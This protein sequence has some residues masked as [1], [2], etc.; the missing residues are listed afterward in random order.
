MTKDDIQNYRVLALKYRPTTFDQLIGQEAM[1]RTLENSFGTNRLA[2]AFILT[3]VRGV[4]KT[5]TARIIARALNCTGPKQSQP[6]RFD[7]CGKCEN[8]VAIFE[9]RHVDVLEIDAASHTGVDRMRAIIDSVH[10]SPVSAKSKVYI[11]DEIHMLST[12]AF[13]ALLK[14]LE[15]PPPNVT[16][17]F[18]TTEIRKVP[19]TVLS[20]CQRFDLR[21]IPSTVLESHLSHVT[22]CEGINIDEV[23]I[24]II[25]RAAEGSVRDALSLLDKA[26]SY[27]ATSSESELR[28]LLGLAD[29]VR[30]LDLLE[31]VFSGHIEQALSILRE[32]YEAGADPVVVFQTLLEQTHLLTR[33]KVIPD[34][35]IGQELNADESSMLNNMAQNLDVPVLTRT[36]QMLLKGLQE[37]QTAPH[38]LSAAEMVLVRLCH[39][40]S[41]PTPIEL[42][43]QLSDS[44]KPHIS[45]HPGE[46]P[47]PAAQETP[48][49]A[50]Q[51]T[52]VPFRQSELNPKSF[53]ELTELTAEHK[54]MRLY[55]NLINDVRLVNFSPGRIEIFLEPSAPE[56]LPKKLAE[57][58]K[59]WTG[60]LW[61]IIVTDT[62]V[63]QTLAQQ[64]QS[65]AEERQAKAAKHPTVQS[66]MTTFPGA[67]IVDIHELSQLDENEIQNNGDNSK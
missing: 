45:T 44:T 25:A 32:Q 34:L 40:S 27:G 17:I 52:S 43:K 39:A 19:I 11:I 1:V 54:E 8:C 22:Q 33:L 61:D 64:H 9:D 53:S 26:I 41:L 47:S 10:Y 12:A 28:H 46:T 59:D 7:P 38:Q 36:W 31:S 3:G 50:A 13:N 60:S 15:E 58:L 30:T 49:P 56:S 5:T 24:S 51:E 66:V 29:N 63:G 4:G 42:V 35:K 57:C 23:S 14:T 16:F 67:K 21:R 65:A 18:A 20:R 62:P 2:Q 37:T 6:R 48:S 55:A